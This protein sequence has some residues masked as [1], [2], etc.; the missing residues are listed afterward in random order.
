MLIVPA[1]LLLGAIVIGLIPG[2]VPGM[3]VAAAHFVDHAAYTGWVLHGGP[4]H[5]APASTS[6][7]EGFDFLY[8]AGAALGAVAVALLGLFGRPLKAR[9]PGVLLRPAVLAV[10]GL[11][12]LHSGH[13]GDYIAWWTGGAA[14][15]GGASLVF[16][17]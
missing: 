17:R 4:P 11:R 7:V 12:Q 9:V 8:G 16:L 1:L 3:E 5:F 15:L 6:H 10:D 13:I 2:A 14:L